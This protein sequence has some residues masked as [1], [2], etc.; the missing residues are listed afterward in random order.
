NEFAAG[1]NLKP[2]WPSATVMKSLLAIAVVPSFLKRVPLVM[3]VILKWVTSAPSAPFRLMTKPDVVWVS[4]LVVAFVTDGVSAIAV[5][6]I[7]AVADPLLKPP[8]DESVAPWTWKLPLA[9]EFA[10][11]VNLKPA[12]PSAKVMKSLFAI[13]VVPSFLHGVRSAV[14]GA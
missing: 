2:A 5:T 3:L 1:V 8:P 14:L 6:V 7:V 12:L 10:A 13:A 4:S 11:G 9:N